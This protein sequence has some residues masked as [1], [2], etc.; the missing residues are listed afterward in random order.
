MFR[1]AAIP[2]LILNM[3][4]GWADAWS[5]DA[6]S[7]PLAGS[8]AGSSHTER[9]HVL[10]VL[11]AGLFDTV[12]A[13]V[14]KEDTDAIFRRHEKGE[15]DKE[16]AC[17]D[18]RSAFKAIKSAG[19]P[20]GRIPGVTADLRDEVNV[21]RRPQDSGITGIV[22]LTDYDM[23]DYEW[24]AEEM[25]KGGTLDKLVTRFDSYGSAGLLGA[26]AWH[27]LH[28]L[29]STLHA[30]QTGTGYGLKPLCHCDVYGGNIMF[31]Q[32]P[33]IDGLSYP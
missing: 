17:Q 4:S 16:E 20:F 18:L 32:A 31:R 14:S 8:S 21:L 15:I 33:V 29:A 28:E 11:G 23:V 13:C 5:T 9:Y 7:L 25:P 10:K 12:H 27:V 19:G 26:F 22:R 2:L 24:L 30:M 1:G 6:S 3:A